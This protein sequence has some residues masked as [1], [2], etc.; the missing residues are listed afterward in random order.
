MENYGDQ[1]ISRD[2]GMLLQYSHAETGLPGLRAGCYI[3]HAPSAWEKKKCMGRGLG[4]QFQNVLFI[5]D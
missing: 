2:S 1:R 5:F 3:V 4:G